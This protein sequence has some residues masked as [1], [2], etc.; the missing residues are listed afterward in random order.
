MDEGALGG[1]EHYNKE[2]KHAGYSAGGASGIFEDAWEDGTGYSGPRRCKKSKTDG[3]TRPFFSSYKWQL[4]QFVRICD[5][6]LQPERR[7]IGA[8]LLPGIEKDG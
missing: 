1:L 8:S 7:T 3:I 4:N 2:R 6:G 5:T